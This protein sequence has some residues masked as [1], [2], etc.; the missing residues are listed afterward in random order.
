MGDATLADPEKAKGG[1]SAILD[2]L[3][4]LVTDIMAM[5]P[6]GEL[7]PIERVSMRP[8]EEVEAVLRGPR[9]PGGRHLYTFGYPP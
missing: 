8:R 7:P 1:V 4:R 5:Y 9:Q 2:Y 3:E 6:P